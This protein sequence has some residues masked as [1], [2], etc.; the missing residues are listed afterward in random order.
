MSK[1][2]N[3]GPVQNLWDMDQNA[4]VKSCFRSGLKQ[5][6][7]VQK[8]SFWTYRRTGNNITT[9]EIIWLHCAHPVRHAAII[10][11]SI[12]R[13]AYRIGNTS[14]FLMSHFN[15]FSV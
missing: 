12:N 3:I 1:S 14:I 2:K 11:E 8:I 15:Y 10:F 6:K 9:S 4:T 7:E 13:H 5:F